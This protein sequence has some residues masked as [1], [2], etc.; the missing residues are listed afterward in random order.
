MWDEII[1]AIISI[2]VTVVGTAITAILIPAATTWLKSRT[3]NQKLQTVIDD[4]TVTVQSSVDMLEQTVVAQLKAD[5]KW[6]KA[7][8]ERVLE[9][10]VTEVL[11]GLNASTYNIIDAENTDIQALVKRHI[12]AYI[13]SKKSAD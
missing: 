10:A 2:V 5:G 6:N 9:D 12:E 1:S 7:A 13:N 3:Q 11:N 4:L 8:Q